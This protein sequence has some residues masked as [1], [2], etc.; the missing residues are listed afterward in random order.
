MKLVKYSAYQIHRETSAK[1]KF[2]QLHLWINASPAP[3]PKSQQ[4][5]LWVSNVYVEKNPE[6]L[7]RKVKTGGNYPT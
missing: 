5:I 7:L 3:P 2:F 6:S 4:I 1:Y